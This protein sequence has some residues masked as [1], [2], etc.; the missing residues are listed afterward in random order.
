MIET[1]F[2]FSSIEGVVS[3]MDGVLWRGDI[4]LPGLEALFEHLHRR[5]LPI[6]LASNNS[7][8]SQA[9]YRDKLLGLGISGMS[10][11]RIVTSRTVL[12]DY[13]VHHYQLGTPVYVIG[14]SG[15]KTA[16]E[17]TGY[18]LSDDAGLVVVGIDFELTYAKLRRA[19]LLIEGGADFLATNGDVSIP[20]SEGSIPGNGAIVAAL[21]SATGR[22][23]TIMGKPARP[24]YDA[25]LRLLG[26]APQN[27][28]MV[29]DRLDTDIVG[30]K[31]SGLQTAL[32]LS[33]ATDEQQ[34]ALSHV[35]PD[36]VFR[37]LPELL[38][39]WHA[40]ERSEAIVPTA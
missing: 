26:T 30:G 3:D 8:K 17:D 12:L 4:A 39:A 6:V 29:G 15:M 37:G 22:V 40:S 19:A 16:M 2:D 14:S 34:V 28:L 27:T 25:A 24:I 9:E 38:S 10:E 20:S 1:Q 11:S 23:P 33:G 32:V 21:Q 13:L 18:P 31:A 36:A 35:R 7:G 5:R